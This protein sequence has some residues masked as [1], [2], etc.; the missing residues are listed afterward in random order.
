MKALDK[1]DLRFLIAGWLLLFLV[2]FPLNCKGL[3]CLQTPAISYDQGEKLLTI[4]HTLG[5]AGLRNSVEFAFHLCDLGLSFI[6]DP[7]QQKK[8]DGYLGELRIL[9]KNRDDAIFEEVSFRKLPHSYI[10]ELEAVKLLY[11][12][13][14]AQMVGNLFDS[15]FNGE[16][17]RFF[18]AAEM[19]NMFPGLSTDKEGYQ[20][21]WEVIIEGTMIDFE[22]VPVS[23]GNEE[24]RPFL[25]SFD[26]GFTFLFTGNLL[27]GRIVID[28]SQASKIDLNNW[29]PKK[30]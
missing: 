28:K 21:Q 14:A 17:F 5:I 26:K 10:T 18:S 24:L 22:A 30:K 15:S 1:F 6:S 8:I 9:R 4:L 20:V 16:K 27:D 12:L 29:L 25:L 3:A 23:E 11:R 19:G 2:F 7:E 13:A